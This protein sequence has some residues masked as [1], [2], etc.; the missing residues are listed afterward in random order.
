MTLL[1]SIIALVILGLAAVGALE[2]LGG[3]SRTTREA[4]AWARAV[5]YAEAG[6]EAAKL[7]TAGVST[8]GR[9]DAPAPGYT[10][11]IDV[12]PWG[13]RLA[14]VTVTVTLPAGRAF[15]VHRLVPAP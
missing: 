15:V 5:A 12:R 3:A 1:E 14:D 2:L 13:P 11:R 9:E 10:R 7:G 8:L 4:E 6:V